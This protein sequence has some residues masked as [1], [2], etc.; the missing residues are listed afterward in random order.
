MKFSWLGRQCGVWEGEH[1]EIKVV[2]IFDSSK[3][4]RKTTIF[5]PK[6]W[7]DE[8]ISVVEPL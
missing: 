7:L 6:I 1:P 8:E 5:Q 4:A 2:S 3:L